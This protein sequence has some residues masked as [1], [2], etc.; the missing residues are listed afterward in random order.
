M[1]VQELNSLGGGLHSPSALV[2]NSLTTVKFPLKNKYCL[3]F[4]YFY[5]IP[6]LLQQ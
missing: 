4:A 5:P 1:I 2:E 3:S 6:E